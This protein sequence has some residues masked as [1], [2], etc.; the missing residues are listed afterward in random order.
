MKHTRGGKRI[1]SGAP[2]KENTAKSH[3]IRLT[4]ADWLKFQLLGGIKW[5]RNIIN[6]K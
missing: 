6:T 2:K 5:L 4:D 1:N 3:T